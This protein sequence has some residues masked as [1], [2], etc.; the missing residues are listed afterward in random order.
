LDGHTRRCDAFRYKPI[1]ITVLV[2]VNIIAT[3]VT[4]TRFRLVDRVGVVVGKR[5]CRRRRR[6]CHHLRRRHRLSCLDKA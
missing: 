6:L 2:V 4:V 1:A 5:L 3:T